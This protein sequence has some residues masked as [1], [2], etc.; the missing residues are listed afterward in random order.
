MEVCDNMADK[1]QQLSIGEP[2]QVTQSNRKRW[3]YT[4]TW[5]EPETY[6]C[7]HPT[8]PY[9][10]QVDSN[11]VIKNYKQTS[12]TL[13]RDGG[14]SLTIKVWLR[15]KHEVL[16]EVV[17]KTITTSTD[18]TI[19]CESVKSREFK[20]NSSTVYLDHNSYI[21]NLLPYKNYTIQVKVTNNKDLTTEDM[22]VIETWELEPYDSPVILRNES[23]NESC[24]FIQ[25]RSP[26][27]PN[28][29]INRYQ[30]RYYI[31]GKSASQWMIYT[32][33]QTENSHLACGYRAGNLVTY[34]IRAGTKVG[35][36]PEATGMLEYLW[37][38]IYSGIFYTKLHTYEHGERTY[39]NNNYM[40]TCA[41]ISHYDLTIKLNEQQIFYG[42]YAAA[43]T[44]EKVLEDLDPYTNY[45]IILIAVNN[46]LNQS[47]AEP[48]YITTP[49]LAPYNGPSL[50][51]ELDESCVYLT[52]QDPD[53]P[54]GIITEYQYTCY[55]ANTEE[56]NYQ[57]ILATDK[58]PVS[59]CE[60]RSAEK[61]TCSAKANNSAG[62]SPVTSQ[63]GYTKIAVRQNDQAELKV[64]ENSGTSFEITIHQVTLDNKEP[65]SY[66]F[67]VQKET[68]TSKRKKRSSVQL[69]PECDLD[70]DCY[71]TAEIDSSLV[72]SDGY[73]FRVGDGKTYQDY[74]NAPL[75]PNQDYKI[76]QA[77][78][79]QM[80]DGTVLTEYFEDPITVYLASEE[81]HCSAPPVVE[82]A[83]MLS[84]DED[85]VM[86]TTALYS[87]EEGFHITGQSELVCG[88]D[89][90]VVEWE[91]E[92][93][94]CKK[95]G[96][97]AKVIGLSVGVS[98]G[99]LILITI[100][101][102]FIWRKTRKAK[103]STSSNGTQ[104]KLEKSDEYEE[105]RLSSIQRASTDVPEY[106]DVS[107]DKNPAPTYESMNT[108][109]EDHNYEKVVHTVHNLSPNTT[110]YQNMKDQC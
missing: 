49:E 53:K 31:S 2:S 18:I 66:V 94:I 11:S 80:E 83:R 5:Q 104:L 8:N 92:I 96:V 98:S 109:T 108:V 71:I 100:T 89:N 54:N 44:R 88:E 79:V 106:A 91:G 26:S 97:S 46:A 58:Q 10:L 13:Y 107:V 110:L 40:E 23:Y 87:C 99:A 73:D 1:P 7:I 103:R 17:T 85:W 77:V 56:G 50:S 6:G 27:Q 93:P 20:L 15:N 24:I 38:S 95:L 42:K 59:L 72:D 68:S 63:T 105:V 16:S 28:G 69:P 34:E 67:V 76:Y 43:E 32:D 101:V 84:S 61:V 65:H 74:Y 39:R 3:K 81:S 29:V 33:V 30:H 62:E 35:Y 41:S 75:E 4:I 14:V 21:N 22:L 86:G 60:F 25:W 12:H 47:S 36:G 70:P 78:T 57:S 48:R 55:Y 90:G 19:N 37:L 51:I 45:T 64:A 52:I 102:T 82:N 9:Q